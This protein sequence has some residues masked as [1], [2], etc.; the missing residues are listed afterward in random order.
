MARYVDLEVGPKIPVMFV[1]FNGSAPVYVEVHDL[2]NG[3]RRATYTFQN[4]NG[5]GWSAVSG[6]QYEWTGPNHR[7]VLRIQA[8]S[9]RAPID[10]DQRDPFRVAIGRRDIGG[11]PG[12]GAAPNPWHGIFS[13]ERIDG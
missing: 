6:Y 11:W 8:W 10:V 2:L 1:A 3:T 13:I 5:E 12:T 9:R 4:P 7:R